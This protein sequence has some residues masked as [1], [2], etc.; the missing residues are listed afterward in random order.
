VLSG[1]GLCVELIT[2]PKSPTEC[3]V[4]ECDTEASIMRKLWPNKGFCYM[5][6]IKQGK[7]HITARKVRDCCSVV[8]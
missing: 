8:L 5:N 2:S 6:K 1:R 3:G 7:E 4:S